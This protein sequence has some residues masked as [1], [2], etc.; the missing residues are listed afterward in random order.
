MGK[1]DLY[2]GSSFCLLA[3]HWTAMVCFWYKCCLMSV[4]QWSQM[5]RLTGVLYKIFKDRG[6]YAAYQYSSDFHVKK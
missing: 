2:F 6:G 4:H 5:I 3:H 1:Y